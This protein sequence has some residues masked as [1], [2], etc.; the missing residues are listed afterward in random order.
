MSTGRASA[1]P[2]KAPL[3]AVR[4][5][6]RTKVTEKATHSGKTCANRPSPARHNTCAQAPLAA[7]G[8]SD[9]MFAGKPQACRRTP[10][11]AKLC[12]AGDGCKP[13]PWRRQGS[14]APQGGETACRLDAQRKS[15]TPLAGGRKGL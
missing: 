10:G 14:L 13:S 2:L 1:L 7:S 9:R 5:H 15:P 6:A 4:R 8:R 11:G 12:A 3:G